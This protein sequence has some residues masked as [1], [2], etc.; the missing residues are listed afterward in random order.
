M[1]P[2]RASQLLG[3]PGPSLR[4]TSLCLTH[5]PMNML[6]VGNGSAKDLPV[7]KATGSLPPRDEPL[8]DPFTHEFALGREWIRKGPPGC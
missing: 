1:D 4:G 6:Q 2:Q 3:Q 8:L 5:S 7:A